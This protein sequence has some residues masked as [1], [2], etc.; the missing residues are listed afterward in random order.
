VLALFQ[1]VGYIP[2]SG[3]ESETAGTNL[4]TLLGFAVRR[5]QDDKNIRKM[6]NM[7]R[8]L[9]KGEVVRKPF[10]G[11]ES[12]DTEDNAEE[13]EEEEEEEEDEMEENGASEKACAK[14]TEGDEAD[15]TTKEGGEEEKKTNDPIVEPSPAKKPATASAA[16]KK[17]PKL[18]PL[19]APPAP[20][21]NKGK[22]STPEPENS[23]PE[24]APHP[25]AAGSGRSQ[26]QK[27]LDDATA[28]IRRLENELGVHLVI[29]SNNYYE[30]PTLTPEEQH[31]LR[32]ALKRGKSRTGGGQQKKPAAN[33]PMKKPAAVAD[34]D[35][36]GVEQGAPSEPEEEEAVLKKPSMKADHNGVKPCKKPAARRAERVNANPDDGIFA[37]RR[38]PK[39]KQTYMKWCAI[40]D[41][42]FQHVEP[43]VTQQSQKQVP[44]GD[45]NGVSLMQLDWSDLWED[46]QMPEVIRYLYGCKDLL[47]KLPQPLKDKVASGLACAV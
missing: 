32:K 30:K 9:K 23:F 42:F 27:E 26:A 34:I 6:F 28:E 21:R 8:K 44:S 24:I 25:D 38:P 11:E 46:A 15:D 17:Q 41:V 40:R 13:Q 22:A 5:E 47:V 4:K 19:P 36:D 14:G 20:G 35:M 7:I 18:I 31:E 43:H 1:K 2:E 33:T 37:R 45:I 39:V 10:V 3:K 29:F 16:P 12:E